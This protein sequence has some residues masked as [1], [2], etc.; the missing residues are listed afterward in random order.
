MQDRPSGDGGGEGEP[1]PGGDNGNEVAIIGASV[2][3]P[4]APDLETFWQNLRAGVE[5]V[6][7]FSEAELEPSP[8][9][10]EALRAHP[11]FVRAGGVLEGADLFDHD[12]F[13]VAP[14]EARWMDPQQRVFLETAWAA[15]E[16]AGVDPERFGGKIALYAGAAPSLHA[17]GL[18]GEVRGDAASLF[19]ALG[20]SGPE[21]MAT[22]AS[23][24]LGLRG[25][26][27]SVYTACSTGLA[28]VHLA[29][30]SLLL[31]QSDIAI[32]G[33]VRVALPQKTGYLYQEGMIF[34]PD[35]RCRAFDRR[36][37]GTVLGQ[38][39]AAVVLKPLD[40]ARRDGDVIHAVIRG[41]ALNNDGRQ[42]AGYTAPSVEGQ[43][44]V[45]REALA[46][47]GLGPDAIGYLEAHGTGTPLGDPIEIAAL[48]RVFGGEGPARERR[49]LGSVKTNIGHL[50]AAAGLAGLVK[51]MLA[52]GR[53]EVPPSLHFEAANPAAD[54]ERAPFYVNTELRP[55]PASP[56][57]RRAGVSSFGIGGTNAHAVLEEAPPRPAPAPSRPA[58]LVTLSAR[59]PSALATMERELAA[60]LEAHPEL[61]LA[62]VAFT[63]AMGRKAFAYRRA[64]VAESPR[65]LAAALAK[66]RP[67]APGPAP[68][69]GA[70]AGV[71]FLFPG[72]GAQHAGM[73]RA[74]WEAEPDFR[75]AL[76]QCFEGLERGLARELRPLLC[77]A[78]RGGG[79]DP[80][81]DPELG[82]PALFAVEYALS[83][84]WQRWGVAPA[85]VLGHSF[86][87]YAAACVAGVFSLEAGL[88]LASLRGRLM[89]RLPPGRM[90]AVATSE[91]TL[92]PLLAEHGLALA[93][94]NGA[95]RCVAAGRPEAIEALERALRGRG[96]AS[97]ALPARQA[98]HSP[99]V[100][101]LL[102]EIERAVARMAPRPPSLPFASSA[103]GDWL[104]GD[105]ATK[106][107]YWA[108][109]MRVTVRFADGLDA[110]LGRGLRLWLE[111]GPER[112]LSSLGRHHGGG[113]S[114]YASLARRGQGEADHAALLEAAGALWSGGVELD[115]AAFFAHERRQR[116]SLP[117]YPFERK[118]CGLEGTS[119]APGELVA[120]PRP[121]S[122]LPSPPLAPTLSRP[123]GMAP[124]RSGRPSGVAPAGSGRPSAAPARSERPSE[125]L[126]LSEAPPT[127][128]GPRDEIER[129][130]ME[131]W[132]ER[133]G[134]IE[135]GVH[136]N[137]LELGGNSLMA[138]QLLTRLRDA[139]QVQLPLGALFEAPTVA[140]VAA[141]IAALVGVGAGPEGGA[142]RARPLAAA[143]RGEALALSIVQERVLELARHDPDNPALI[144]MASIELEGE[145]DADA[146]ERAVGEVAR[147]HEAL[148]T[149][150]VERGGRF[151]ARV[152]SGAGFGLV[153]EELA[154]E[155]WPA[156]ARAEAERPFDLGASPLRATLL[157]AGPRR[158]A[159]LVGVHHVVSDTLSMVAFVREAA[160]N[161][162]ALV[163][164]GE[165]PL[166]PLALQYADYAAWQR[167]ALAGGDFAAQAEHWRRRLEG[168]GGP[169]DLPSDRPRRP[170]GGV[171]GA[172]H[173]FALPAELGAAARA[174]GRREGVT[175][176]MTVLAAFAAL[177]SRATGSDDVVVGTPVGNRDRGELEPL[178]GYVAHALPLRAD[179]SGDPDFRE[180]ARRVKRTTLDAYAHADVPY[181]WLVREL[182]PRKDP[183][184]E[185]LFDALFVLHGGR[186]VE[187]TTP[188]GL[189]WRVLEVPEAPAQFGV[190]LAALSISLSEAA[191]GGYEGG[192]EYATDRFDAATAARL[193][194]QLETLLAAAL[195]EPGRKLSALPLG[196]P[197][198]ML[199]ALPL[200]EPERMLS[201][202]PLGA[203]PEASAAPIA[204]ATSP[205]PLA[206][207]ARLAEISPEG[208]AVRAGG[209]TLRYG[210]LARRARG[211]AA[212][213]RARGAGEGR[214]VFVALPPSPERWVAALGVLA[215]GAAYA[216][217]D[218]ARLGGPAYAP[219]DPAR[220]GGPAPE[221]EGSLVIV[222]A[223]LD[224]PAG[225]AG[226]V[227]LEALEGEGQKLIGGAPLVDR[228]AAGG[229]P[230]EARDGRP[231]APAWAA[232]KGGFVSYAELRA[233]FDGLDGR[234]GRPREGGGRW[235]ALGEPDAAAADLE[236][237]WALGRGLEIVLAE[238]PS[239]ARFV[240]L[241]AAP[242]RAVAFSL[243]YFANDEDALGGAKYRL[244]LEGAKAA[245]RRGLHA[246]WT[247]ER[248]F[249]A[250]G[251][252]YPS[253]GAIGAALAAATERVGIRAGSVVLP[254]HD[255][256]RVAEEWSV[257]D[258]LSGGRAGV[259]FASGWNADDFVFAPERY[260][261]RKEAMLEG[262]RTVLALW[263]GEALRRTN[264]AGDEIEVRLRPRP[265]QPELPFWLT[266][267]G[268]P[269]TFRLAGELGAGVLTNLMGQRLDD[270]AEKVAVY[271][272]AWRRAGRGP[273]RGHV[274]LMMHAFVG[275]GD[276]GARRTARGPLARYFRSSIDIFRGFAASQGLDLRPE[277]LAPS[278]LDALV[279]HGLERY[280]EEGGLFG[281][282][283]G[284]EPMVERVRRLDV[285]EIA[286]LV[287]FGVGV[288]EALAGIERLG[289]LRDRAEARAAA[290][291]EQVIA[292]ARSAL[293]ALADLIAS[294]GATHLSCDVAIVEALV[295]GGRGGALAG[296][297]VAAGGEPPTAEAWA[298][299]C[300][301]A[302][303]LDLVAPDPL[304][305]RSLEAREGRWVI[306]AREGA[307]PE[308]VDDAGRPLPAGVVGWA[309]APGGER[310][311]ARRRGDGAIELVADAARGPRRP[312][313]APAAGP[314]PLRRAEREG[315]LPLS[316]AQQRLWYLDH[317]DPGNV[318]YN[319]AVAFRLSGELDA[320]ALG[321]ALD[322]V[323]RRHEAL[324]TAFAVTPEG[325]VQ[326]VAP[327]LSLALA[328]H[329]V[330]GAEDAEARAAAIVRAEA[331]LP[332]DLARVPLVRAA[333][334]RVA[335]GEHVLG[336][337]LHH[338]VS[339]GW[340]A[341]VLASEIVALYLAF[342]AGAPSPLPELPVQY[343]DYAAW[344]RAWAEAG[345]LEGELAYWKATLGGVPPLEL[346]F[347]RPRGAAQGQRGGREKVALGAALS[348]SLAA[349]GRRAGATL[350]VVLVAA[351]KALLHRYSGQT[352]LALGT[353]VAGRSRP[354][355]EPL[356]GCFVN[357]LVLRTDLS[358]D[359]SFAE[360]V[361][362]VRAVT[363]AALAHQEVPF[364]QVVDALG[365][366]RDLSHTPLFQAMLVLHN[367]PAPAVELPGLALRAAE[368][369][370]GAAKLDLTLELLEGS[371]GLEGAFEYN[372]DLFDAAT[373]AQ[374]SRHFVRLLGAALATPDRPISELPLLD[375][376][377]GS[378][379]LGEAPAPSPEGEVE[380]LAAAFEAQ[381]RRR[382]D[383]V[384]VRSEGEG[385]LTYRELDA[386]ADRA[387][388][389]LRAEGVGPEARVAV[390]VGRP[391]ETVA[392]FL[393][394][395]KAGG[396]YVPLDPA[397]PAERLAAL[398]ACVGP[399]ATLAPR[400][401]ERP[402]GL[403]PAP[404][405][406]DELEGPGGA[407]RPA[408]A[409]GDGGGRPAAAG[410]DGGDW[411]AAA[412]GD[413]PA[414]AGG[415]GGARPATAGGARAAYMLFTSG[416]GGGPKGV[417]VEH[418]N[419][420]AS[421]RA[422]VATYGEAGRC[423]SLPPFSFDASAAGLYW[424]LLGGGTLCYPAP[425][426]REDPRRLAAFVEAEGAEQLV[427]VPAVYATLIESAAP[428]QL[429][430]LR[431]VIVGGEAC[432][433]PL[434]LAHH[435]ALPRAALYNEYGPTEAT[436]WSTAHRTS[437]AE[438][439]PVPIGR[440][441]PGVRAYVLD[442]RL[443]PVP[444]GAP[445]ELYIGGPGVARGYLDAPAPTAER[446]VPSPFGGGERLHRTGDRVRLRRDGAL[447]FLGRVDR[448]VKVRGQ[449]VE[450]GEIEAALSAHPGVHEAF[451]G[452]YAPGGARPGLVA[453]VAPAP[454]GP[455]PDAGAIEA[456]LR[457]RLPEALVP[458]ACVVLDALPR[459]PNGKVDAKALAARVPAPP[460]RAE[461][462]LPRSAVE[463][464]LVA[465]MKDVLAL[466]AVGVH[467]DFFAL[468]G[469]SI[470]SIQVVVRARQAGIELKPR[471][472]FEAPT[473]AKLAEVAGTRVAIE[474]EQGPVRGPVELTPAQRWFFE[475]GLP[476]PQH[477]N[478]SLLL[479][480][481]REVP[482]AV[483]ERA[484]GH[485]LEHH[486]A[487]RLRFA[488]SGEGWRQESA[489]PGGAPPFE[490]VDLSGLPE[491][492]REGALDEAL[493][494]LQ[495]SLDLE[496]GP[497]LRAA[498][499]HRGGGERDLLVFAAHH[500]V[501]DGVSWRVVLEDFAL[502]C[503]RLASGA[504]VRL[505]LKTTSFRAW[506]RRLAAHAD[507]PALRDELPYWLGQAW[508]SAGR[509]PASGP[510]ADNLE[511]RGAEE[512]AALGPDETRAL[513]H[514][515]TR[516]LDARPQELMLGA[517]AGA[518][519]A[520]TG[521]ELALV[522]VETH[523]RAELF[524]EIDVSRTVGW[525]TAFYPA[526]LPARGEAEALALAA[527]AATRAVPGGGI[528]YGLLRYLCRER[529][530]RDALGA[531]PRAEVAFNYL[532]QLDGALPPGAP[533]ALSPRSP[534]PQ[535]APEARRPY[536]LNVD[537]AV[538]GGR[539][540][541]VFSFA[542]GVLPRE[543][544]ARAAAAC[545][546][547]L[548]ALAGRARSPRGAGPAPADFPLAKVSQA[549]LD[550]LGAKFAK[551][552]R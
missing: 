103:T 84:L 452:A 13:G 271:R 468:G 490:R 41:T 267:A 487:L 241:G 223:P 310:R 470:L 356:V 55:W 339:D 133:L 238:A 540:E 255:P 214:H 547:A 337:T 43:A 75:Q 373:A 539:L 304:F 135:F 199:S 37:R 256:V 494:S 270:L 140:G 466:P 153:R 453:F 321:R 220:L 476:S 45:I 486:D 243:S 400:G 250:F 375:E 131:I 197:E 40:D 537:A 173:P 276:E 330:S 10:P 64:V 548:R 384:A 513:L 286:A 93:A 5:S 96:V 448:Q 16:D 278:D 341:G 50:D 354:E 388:R 402:R 372:A 155:A 97:V 394:V 288:D 249:H 269:E 59:T 344:Q 32:A 465:I 65:A 77:E 346:P 92:A 105:A 139:F 111:A 196:E 350:F 300:E 149:T 264:G 290:G 226:A 69:A 28:V 340:S 80:L 44:E 365:V 359:P 231:D 296:L 229:P 495:G 200:G 172:R 222:E 42:K 412:G 260:A 175:P 107:S 518:L 475:L 390:V 11:D 137:F 436:I 458:S 367:T 216:P 206:R 480:L 115:W 311:R 348:A 239:P 477:W 145:L 439:S 302:P 191:D 118:P 361:G 431:T 74:L 283:E 424:A 236:A 378:E 188:G 52:V 228:S 536:L 450:P 251:G 24:K 535:R 185:R 211:V 421:T 102:G 266:A 2:R 192:L 377:E 34:S 160:A 481:T 21:S 426:T 22:K 274:T 508:P 178:I 158:H 12:F 184:R 521:A 395:L 459:T 193:M 511:G 542:P 25:E 201:A 464:R 169:L 70:G 9:V 6:S 268:S 240:P 463:E 174:F 183:G 245:D 265:V 36:A 194:R 363:L 334:V 471:Q 114:A 163:A 545:L 324:R 23:F 407:G 484:L 294:A 48:A 230:L 51:A 207:L 4:G 442:G 374:L 303:G 531:L 119:M 99:D 147:R 195:A 31:R 17:L 305:G 35:G 88:E 338:V 499:V 364:E 150:Y 509:L 510:A 428:G 203:A 280:L 427:A 217:L 297:L 502:A 179:L 488:P 244:L 87:E 68:A 524:A 506:A 527:K 109:Q 167:A 516:A 370:T 500:L 164:G 312:A 33:A 449:R 298:K 157:R 85:A 517:L 507:A 208:V 413:R 202:L 446:F 396:A 549:Q 234:L 434:V 379:L 180:L 329:D 143:P 170:G 309:R 91:A 368:V 405:P 328:R 287:D 314:P 275:E 454:G 189:R 456:W 493:R 176:F 1:P 204:P 182:E 352:D 530:V 81:L 125:A 224:A 61:P 130:V 262:V 277:S 445:G 213:L 98:F 26:S 291:S 141:R 63:R 198:R 56:G 551:K 541:F 422:R 323:V 313:P 54:F 7:F 444:W 504:A 171:R 187:L 457:S 144:M 358:G 315:P 353:P 325:P 318:A 104:E 73:A 221:L 261:R 467:D 151:E 381:A 385:A 166:P 543:A 333:L 415:D 425:E 83:R 404:L 134:T 322:E 71:A 351:L 281:T 460:A 437:P 121:P 360:L 67:G 403:G 122:R 411:P 53:G 127:A 284:C 142:G 177:L 225:A 387:A 307:G 461:A 66:A 79:P 401:W 489:P 152:G 90:L 498:L 299:L 27:V 136:D 38:G 528:G 482:A 483:L 146:L 19:E 538:R 550:A 389:R 209:R 254:L 89:A 126:P 345:G 496:R 416:S 124:A 14:R 522:D 474:A 156:R 237:A 320:D 129:Q 95:D 544:V 15:L 76:E 186:P 46:Y 282:P 289:D 462:A 154:A 408:A 383:A 342:R 308:V 233:L 319:N 94:V 376:G 418:R 473:V 215:A 451:V 235:L 336:L 258:N 293:D 503:E 371:D 205:S 210:E 100:E 110:L 331:R 165:P 273:G 82:L 227:T 526:L 355:L 393:G 248:H 417:V 432:P 440:P 501:V 259:S 252:L 472:I 529:S 316:F 438:G 30:Q 295:R 519:G 218:P 497:L 406:F 242:V 123:P 181:E 247:P 332:F 72:Q 357:S 132:R 414:A 447:E 514:D 491:G 423:L 326:I 399:R 108:R 369:E 317:L 523:G 3:L 398:I 292:E 159:L 520:L 430:S 49:P 435:E 443:R 410:G 327:E 420:L 366:P 39:A 219:L 86:G 349:F 335:P 433:A 212:A 18:L 232:P 469:D 391:L 382:P 525:F 161:Y 409:G 47:A 419:V 57:P 62:D 112:A 552:K 190:T 279:E 512:R 441:G 347:D 285:D 78:P 148:R 392:S 485:V 257:I 343:A 168:L 60:H 117:A 306:A 58:Q 532:G 162:G 20:V 301:E 253:P 120:F 515:A 362:R 429:G 479:E 397:Q 128:E 272:E 386:R 534:G 116:V 29:C 380:S 101:P 492:R 478:M 106:P 246:V 263:R 505:P 533:V 113:A 546:D 138:A 455:R 8:L